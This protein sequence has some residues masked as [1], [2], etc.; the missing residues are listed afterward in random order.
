M[1]KEYEK[2]FCKVVLK[3]EQF[4]GGG[5]KGCKTILYKGFVKLEF[6]SFA[7]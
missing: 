5:V 1:G 3:K 7:K 4:S 2:G 6:T